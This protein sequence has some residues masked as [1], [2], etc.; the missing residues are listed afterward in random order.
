MT[1]QRAGSPTNKPRWSRE[2]F[3]RACARGGLLPSEPLETYREPTMGWVLRPCWGLHRDG[4][5]WHLTHLPTG[6]LVPGCFDT[7]TVGKLFA[8]E[9]SREVDC[10]I[11]SFGR[12]LRGV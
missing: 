5:K 12:P 11:G 9:L 8:E 3:D 6:A 4:G 1:R 7:L 10:N 2:S